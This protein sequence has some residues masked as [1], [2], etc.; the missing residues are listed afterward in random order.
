MDS[1]PTF[2]FE[3]F[4]NFHRIKNRESGIGNRESGIGNRESGIGNRESGS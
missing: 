4:G 2:H 3:G 1:Q